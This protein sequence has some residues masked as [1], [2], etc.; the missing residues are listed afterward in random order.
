MDTLD[1]NVNV[2]TPEGQLASLPQSQLQEAVDS[3]FQQATPEDLANFEQHEKFGGVGQGLKAFTEGLGQ[4]ATFGLSTGLERK[5]GVPSEN[6][7]GREREHPIMHGLGQAA[8]FLIP[9]APEA[10][11]LEA[12]GK[13]AQALAGL[14]EA[15]GL[16]KIG[17]GALKGA[18][19]TS[20]LTSGDEVSKSLAGD[21]DQSVQT[22]AVN[23]GLSG[24]LGAGVG[25]GLGAG[26]ALWDATMGPKVSKI[27]DMVQR[28]SEGFDGIIPNEVSDSLGKLGIEIPGETKA[29]LSGNPHVQEAAQILM[30][31]G[32]LSATKAREGFEQLQ[33]GIK[34]SVMKTVG[35]SLDDLENLPNRS[36]N[37]VGNELK[38]QLVKNFEERAKP[39]TEAFDQT[40]KEFS[41]VPL[42]ETEKAKLI[43]DISDTALKNGY[44]ASASSP[45]A[46]FVNQIIKD[47]EGVQN[48]N[49]LKQLQSELGKQA[50]GNK[51]DFT[52]HD[53][54]GTVGR[55]FRDF[56]D[57]IVDSKLEGRA[58]EIQDNIRFARQ[59][60]KQ[61]MNDAQDLAD[62]IKP[63]HFQGINQFI[64]KIKDMD[65]EAFLK[66]VSVSNRAELLN[67]LKDKAP[68]LLGGLRE[69]QLNTLLEKASKGSGYKDLNTKTL[70][71]GIAEMPP[72]LRAFTFKPEQLQNF[73]G[74]KKIVDSIP[75]RFNPSG[76]ARTMDSLTKY[77]PNSALGILSFLSGHGTG[78]SMLFSALGSGVLRESRDAV[79][80]GLLRFLGNGQHVSAS[81]FKGMVEYIDHMIKGESLIANAAK[82]V[83]KAGAL[84]IPEKMLPDERRLNKLNNSLNKMQEDPK[85]MLDIGGTTTVYLPEHGGALGATAGN[86]VQYLQSIKPDPQKQSVLDNEPKITP[87]EKAQYDRTLTIAEQP[88]VVL[89]HIKDGTLTLRDMSD[90]HALYPALYQ[91]LN[92]KLSDQLITAIDKKIEI[93]YK[94]K[95]SLSLF[96]GQPLDSTMTPHGIQSSQMALM[97]GNVQQAQ[98]Q[99]GIKENVNKLNKF[100]QSD[101]T[102]QQSREAR[103]LKS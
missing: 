29:L 35:K 100:A 73:D 14:N 45:R 103:H 46:K 3:G 54:M 85:K 26:N 71:K 58:P 40:S 57:K 44:L 84:V 67:V 77:I 23:I 102:S 70:L 18:V 94:T 20:L 17:S 52:L 99:Q 19:E 69:H 42:A 22:A 9:G 24:L 16:A 83:F 32:T 37:Q 47:I 10:E 49:G 76:T 82:N 12:A 21:P 89:N 48:L 55:K 30:E 11:A 38:T 97:Q 27:L 66:K 78:A 39:V 79:K 62:Y 56:E 4:G 7:I 93:P 53:I 63:G 101:M 5:A 36:E 1:Q 50:Y 90:I 15:K 51:T 28:K 96:M 68:E 80:L 25:G 13:G 72:E 81:G 8:S 6:I 43:E 33:T 74:L 60:Y 98:K 61:L 64:S 87:A 59:Q 2:V 31:G 95:L 34:D 65:P 92:S 86:A 88:L 91:K 41:A 75:D